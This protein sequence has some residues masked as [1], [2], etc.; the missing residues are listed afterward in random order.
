MPIRP[1]ENLRFGDFRQSGEFP[2]EGGLYRIGSPS[3]PCAIF[4]PRCRLRTCGFQ[5][6]RDLHFGPRGR[7]GRRLQPPDLDPQLPDLRGQLCVVAFH[8]RRPEFEHLP[9]CGVFSALG[10]I[11][12]HAVGQDL[13]VGLDAPALG[14]FAPQADRLQP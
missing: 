3:H 7:R 12:L 8:L 1:S 14:P 5:G 11:E 4:L 2:I 9:G 10:S 6:R 13:V